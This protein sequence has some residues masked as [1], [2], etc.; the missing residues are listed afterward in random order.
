MAPSPPVHLQSKQQQ[1]LSAT[2]ILGEHGDN[3]PVALIPPIPHMRST[4]G[5]AMAEAF[6]SSL[7]G[8]FPLLSPAVHPVQNSWSA[9]TCSAP[10][11]GIISAGTSSLHTNYWRGGLLSTRL[12]L[13]FAH[14]WS[15][16][17]HHPVCNSAPHALFS[18]MKTCCILMAPFIKSQLVRGI[19]LSTLKHCLDQCPL[20]T[21]LGEFR[22]DF[23]NVSCMPAF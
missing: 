3:Y 5:P 14:C 10:A 7:T 22:C 20:E 15:P 13:A 21:H 17:N 2:L 18:K 1:V 4:V 8:L 23:G 9:H 16:Y 12:S 6:L 11:A 19:R